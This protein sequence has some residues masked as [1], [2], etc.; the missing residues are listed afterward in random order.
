[1][2]IYI[3]HSTSFDYQHQLYIPIK[4]SELFSQH[5]FILPHDHARDPIN[6]K[7][8][9]ACCDLI[10]AEVSYPSTGQGIELGWAHSLNIPIYC[11]HLKDKKYSSSLKFIS[12][13]IF[14][15]QNISDMLHVVNLFNE[16]N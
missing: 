3:C 9:I 11:F 6:S 14:L 16:V 12:N 1:M 7:E 5:Q 13:N 8:Q 15:Y 2:N 4:Q 10:I